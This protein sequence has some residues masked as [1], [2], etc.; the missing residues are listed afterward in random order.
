[1]LNTYTTVYKLII[2]ILCVGF[3]FL[4][5]STAHAQAGQN[6]VLI[7]DGTFLGQI[8][9]FMTSSKNKKYIKAFKEFK[10]FYTGGGLADEEK[11]LVQSTSLVMLDL[12]LTVSPYFTD[13]YASLSSMRKWDTG[14]V[15]F[16]QYHEVLNGLLSDIDGRKLNPFKN[17]LKFATYFF[18]NRTLKYSNAG[19]NWLAKSKDYDFEYKDAQP[20]ISFEKLDLIA[21]RKEDS[22][23]LNQT[24]GV[25]FP[26]ETKWVGKGGVVSWERVDFPDVRAEI[27]NYEIDTK[28]AFYEVKGVKLFYQEYF[29]QGPI[30]GTFQDK[31][32]AGNAA[33]DGSYPRFESDESRLSIKDLGG[34]IRYEGGFRLQGATMYGYG[35]EDMPA[36]LWISHIG[37]EVFIGKSEMFI[38][39]KQEKVVAEKVNSQL[40]F[41]KDTLFHPSINMTYQIPSKELKLKRGKSGADQN[42][43]ID[44]YHQI[45]LDAPTID[46][47]IDT[48]TIQIGIKRPSFANS[49]EKKVKF[50]SF[51]FFDQNEFEKI[52][53]ISNSNPLIVMRIISDKDMSRDLDAQYLAQK[54]NPR[55]SVDNVKSLY[56]DLVSKGFID[57]DEDN[58]R[59]YLLDKLFHYTD[60]TAEKVDYDVLGVLSQTNN[61]NAILNI[62]T[63]AYE[64]TGVNSVEFS[65]KQKVAAK[66]YQGYLQMHKNRSLL[67]DGKL[68]AGFG[69]FDGTD[70][71]FEYPKFTIKADSI[72]YFDLFVPTGAEDENGVMEATSIASRIEHAYGYLQIDAP[73][74]KS[75]LEDLENF[76]SF[77]T[78]GPSYVFYDYEETKNGAYKRDSFY[79]ELAK[80]NFK[81]LDRFTSADVA[82]KGSLVS[83]DIF[84]DFEET[85]VIQ[86]DDSS[87][88]FTTQTTGSGFP[89]YLDK[90][91]YNGEL[92]LSNKGLLGVGNLQYLNASIDSEDIVFKPKQLLASAKAFHTDEER[93]ADPNIPQVDGEDVT[94]NWLP[95]R[96]SMYVNT[97][98]DPFAFYKEPGYSLDGTLILTPSGVKGKG[99]FEWE[100]GLMKSKLF[101]Y[102]AFSVDSDTTS[103][104]IKALEGTNFAFDSKNVN[105]NVNFDQQIGRFKA[106][107][108][109]VMTRLPYN[110]YE[111]TMN[112]FD[113]DMKAQ[114][115]TFISDE[116]GSFISTHPNQDSL[117]FEGANAFYDLTTSQLSVSGVPF[118]ETADAFVYPKDEKVDIEANAKITQLED[119]IIVANTINKNHVINRA[120]VDVKGR[121]EYSASGY[122]EYNV[123]GKE[124]EILFSNIVG[125]PVGK[126]K[127]SVKKVVTRGQGE[128]AEGVD[129]YIDDKIKFKGGIGL[130][131]EV[132]DL[133]FDGFA[134]IEAQYLPNA[135][136][137][138][139]DC[140]AEKE[141]LMIPFEEPK[142][143]EGVPMRAGMFLSKESSI[144]YPRMLNPL[145]FRKD[146]AIIDAAG[147]LKY[148][149]KVD[150]FLFG[151]SLKILGQSPRG[152]MLKFSDSDSKIYAEGKLDLGSALPSLIQVQAAGNMETSLLAYQDSLAGQ[153]N[154]KIDIDVMHSIS[155][156][157]PDKL[158]KV[159]LV[160][161]LNT[162]FTYAEPN[163]RV[164]NFYDRAI[165]EFITD[166]VSYKTTVANMKAG[167]LEFP[168]GS[169]EQLFIFGRTPMKWDWDYQSF[170]SIKEKNY[171]IS[172]DGNRMGQN[173]KSYIEY[174]MPSNNDDRLYIL[175]VAPNDYYYFFGYKQG[176]LNT[177]SNNT[178]YNE[179]V[180]G[181]KDKDLKFK[182]GDEEYE[183]QLVDPASA[184]S[185]INRIKAVQQ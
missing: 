17:T 111:T 143:F 64:V 176:V 178:R 7:T 59:V 180:A 126:G 181:L 131:A 30:T 23:V 52:Q 130:N 170:V 90:G 147:F 118:I 172:I 61:T 169:N 51:G 11:Q 37:K 124:Q 66:P 82:F 32:L 117:N 73:S 55:F 129:F 158:K 164:D 24:S 50:E 96:D 161:M 18:D 168:K 20:S 171:V 92:N 173:L 22:I 121:R 97:T 34:N 134:K 103:I 144:I 148:E 84:P 71:T 21:T 159:M 120:S 99:L 140:D 70:F 27:P 114:T 154:I 83:A 67:F 57:F 87:L 94:I 167:R 31:I 42:L 115:I 165:A 149:D 132:K 46:W 163:Y 151:D 63:K 3:S 68:F 4:N 80:F 136:W 133:H 152:N 10:S 86:E 104:K 135:E 45:R 93:K 58:N 65:A 142:N 119:A 56:Y 125:Q 33:A 47:K 108:D 29:P 139:I 153:G 16:K 2:V 69:I 105:A 122:Y 116:P 88:G 9:E 146:R 91:L 110:Q 112:E 89:T 145:Y 36:N 156:E 106:N 185:F 141:R 162:N 26:L 49:I 62:A 78:K 48:D 166:D 53:N 44:E 79:F 38:V 101:S 123:A 81:S 128:I 6:T 150:N 179:T 113:W 77:H 157:L 177:V 74:N 39:K 127:K 100:Q 109:T 8:E 54:I 14:T 76:P 182:K 138:A 40:V 5:H 1:M 75:G 184:T 160:D 85:I 183:I 13:Y 137:F 43:F 60:A 174:K 25:Y 102:G 41:D 72:R 28:K 12:K 35:S 19:V 175:I 95:Y 98:A 155:F 15:N 107:A